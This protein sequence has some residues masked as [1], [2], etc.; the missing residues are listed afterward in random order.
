VAARAW[1]FILF[2]G[3]ALLP[4][5]A[6][7]LT[8]SSWT[9]YQVSGEDVVYVGRWGWRTVLDLDPKTF[10]RLGEDLFGSCSAGYA[11]DARHVFYEGRQVRRADAASFQVAGGPRSLYAKDKRRAYFAGRPLPVSVG[12]FRV[13]GLPGYFATD[14]HAGFWAGKRLPGKDFKL[15]EVYAKSDRAVFFEGKAVPGVVPASFEE[16]VQWPLYAR[17]ERRVVASGR[18][19]PEADPASFEVI[20]ETLGYARDRKRVYYWGEPISGADMQTFRVTVLRGIRSDDRFYGY[21]HA[22]AVCK[23]DP[24][25][26]GALPPC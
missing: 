26:T 6:A 18:I 24:N 13:G 1:L 19:I 22:K 5:P 23:H 11:A 16:F 14:G 17:D 4:A 9:L 20:P 2:L 25:A 10:R 21:E 8:C 12:T 15:M 7:A 3:A